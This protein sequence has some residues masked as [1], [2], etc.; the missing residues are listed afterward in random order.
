[1]NYKFHKQTT[2]HFILF[3][4]DALTTYRITDITWNQYINKKLLIYLY[5]QNTKRVILVQVQ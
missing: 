5:L 1:M 3:Q 4:L 2:D